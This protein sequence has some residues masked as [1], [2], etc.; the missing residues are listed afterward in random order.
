MAHDWTSGDSNKSRDVSSFTMQGRLHVRNRG[1]RRGK[2]TICCFRSPLKTALKEHRNYSHIAN[3]LASQVASL[4]MSSKSILITTISF[5]QFLTGNWLDVEM[6]VVVDQC[7]PLASLSN[8]SLIQASRSCAEA[9][10]LTTRLKFSGC[11]RR[12]VSFNQPTQPV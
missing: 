7:C 6:K 9:L 8:A 5:I 4:R 10:Q 12:M 11:A 1:G 3:A 2:I